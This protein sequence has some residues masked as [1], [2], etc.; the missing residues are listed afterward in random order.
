MKYLHFTH[1]DIHVQCHELAMKVKKDGFC[2]DVIVAVA[3]GGFPVAR[4]LADFLRVVELQSVQIELYKNISKMLDSPNIIALNLQNLEGRKVLVCDDIVD[5][6]TT[7][8]LVI[9]HLKQIENV[10]YKIVT[11]HVKE[12]ADFEPD[13]FHSKVTEWVIYPWELHETISV[14][15]EEGMKQSKSTKQVLE[16]LRQIGLEPDFLKNYETWMKETPE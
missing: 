6:G 1:Q 9:D 15:L 10:D 8:K 5:T 2:P 7:I 3:R 4:L 16:E 12:S 13:Y 14:F 11:L